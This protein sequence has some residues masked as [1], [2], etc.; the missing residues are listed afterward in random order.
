[1]IELRGGG[2]TAC[3]LA[4]AGRSVC[5]IERGRRWAKGDCPRTIGQLRQAFWMI[6][7][8]EMGADDPQT[9]HNG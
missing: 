5:L 6:H 9:P 8:R 1:M 4:Q 7:G 2:I 3:R